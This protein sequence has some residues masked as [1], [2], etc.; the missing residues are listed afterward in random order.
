[1]SAKEI[2]FLITDRESPGLNATKLDNLGW[3]ASDTGEIA[4]QDV[5]VPVEN[6]LGEENEGFFYIMQHFVSERHSLAV[7]AYAASSYV[8]VLPCNI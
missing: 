1:M 7:G 5:K 8:L 4:F 3:R 6:L 2:R